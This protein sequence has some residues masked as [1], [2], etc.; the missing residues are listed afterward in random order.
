MLKRHL[1]VPAIWIALMVFW[2][3][4]ALAEMIVDTAWA[5]RYDG[6]GNS[7]GYAREQAIDNSPSVH[8]RGSNTHSEEAR[9]Y[10]TITYSV[11]DKIQNWKLYRDD[12]Y[13]FEIKYPP[14]LISISKKDDKIVMIHSIEYEH[15]DPCDFKGGAPLLKKLTDFRVSLKL[16]SKNVQETIIATT[17]DYFVSHML[18]NDTLKLVTGYIDT[19]S[20]GTLEGYRVTNGV[21][22][23]GYYAY[24][25]PLNHDHTLLV[26]RSFITELLP[27]IKDSK[28]Y[29]ELP[30]IIP[31]EKEERLFDQILSTLRL[32]EK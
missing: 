1:F 9:N 24:Y 22:G 8:V 32:K 2:A 26:E 17:S 25:F 16:F 15:Q 6:P 30:G 21:E 23:C 29:S 4:P 19:V 11:Q 27:I 7:R 20:I 18:I 5:R 13:G 31:L 3:E 10:D 12:E 14:K 28:K